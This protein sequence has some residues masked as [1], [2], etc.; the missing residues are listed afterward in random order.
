MKGA[1]K[2][3]KAGLRKLGNRNDKAEDE[4]EKDDSDAGEL[5]KK[6]FWTVP[7]YQP[8]WLDFLRLQLTEEEGQ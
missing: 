7:T 5:F 4:S 2:T 3:R 6:H 8:D 1:L